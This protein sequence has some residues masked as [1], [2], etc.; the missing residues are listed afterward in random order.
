MGYIIAEL[1]RRY[2]LK[3][4]GISIP[5]VWAT[6]II[7]ALVLPAYAATT[8]ECSVPTNCFQS[9]ANPEIFFEWPGGTGLAEDVAFY[10]ASCSGEFRGFASVVLAHN[11]EEAEFLLEANA[12]LL[13]SLP[14]FE[15][16][17]FYAES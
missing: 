11:I 2:L 4:L 12:A 16:C 13:L 5:T 1:S 3:C 7:E 6:P 8:G 15:P 9:A 14:G 17:S 10:T